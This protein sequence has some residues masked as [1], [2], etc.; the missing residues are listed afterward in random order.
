MTKKTDN[1]IKIPVKNFMLYYIN[2]MINDEENPFEGLRDPVF[3]RMLYKNKPILDKEIRELEELKKDHPG[4]FKII[5]NQDADVEFQIVELPSNN[6]P[7]GLRPEG[8]ELAKLFMLKI[9][10]DFDAN[11][12]KPDKKKQDKWLK[13]AEK[14]EKE[15]AEPEP[16]PKPKSQPKSKS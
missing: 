13:L 7:R 6:L 16:E 3:V 9:S 8:I 14:L 10:D 15:P 5:L 4:V 11:N 12:F 1:N 2:N